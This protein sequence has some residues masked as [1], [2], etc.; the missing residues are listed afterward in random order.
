MSPTALTASG[1]DAPGRPDSAASSSGHVCRLFA[2]VVP[3]RQVLRSRAMSASTTQRP[4]IAGSDFAALNR[5]IV[6]S[7]LLDR[8]PAYYAVRMSV[9]TA[10]LAAVWVAF[11]LVGASWWN[12]AVAGL[13]GVVFSQTGLLAHDIA[14]RQV[15][16]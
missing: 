2:V 9:V 5:Q 14:H 13:L 7:G 11:A 15:F 10:M 3:G 6:K 1:G 8:R 4:R 16:R 12:I